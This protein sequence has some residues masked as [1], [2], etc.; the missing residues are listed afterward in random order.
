MI[1]AWLVDDIT[2]TLK[3]T[4]LRRDGTRGLDGPEGSFSDSDSESESNSFVVDE[5]DEYEPGSS[6]ILI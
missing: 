6:G 2:R 4:R 5:D 3:K 1:Y